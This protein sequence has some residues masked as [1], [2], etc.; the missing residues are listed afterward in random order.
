M[1][2]TSIVFCRDAKASEE[3]QET[4]EEKAIRENPGVPVITNLEDLYKMPRLQKVQQEEQR[5]KKAAKLKAMRKRLE[6]EEGAHVET[7]QH[8]QNR[9]V[10]P[11]G[12]SIVDLD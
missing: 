8:S 12:P 4:A 10:Q 11:T 3:D 1:T 6:A 2:V 5:K 9:A 7:R